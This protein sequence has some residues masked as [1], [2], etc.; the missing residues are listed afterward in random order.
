MRVVVWDEAV[1]LHQPAHYDLREPG[2]RRCRH[3]R[4]RSWGIPAF[5]FLPR[6][7][8]P[9]SGPPSQRQEVT[10]PSALWR[11]QKETA[12]VTAPGRL[13]PT[14]GL[15]RYKPRGPLRGGYST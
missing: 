11:A 8:C 14:G 2:G 12:G 6:S 1:Y 4:G 13:Y 10:A 15:K 7:L 9:W 5:Q 3:E